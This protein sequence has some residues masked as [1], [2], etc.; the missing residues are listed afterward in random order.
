[1]AWIFLLQVALYLLFRSLGLLLGRYKGG[2]GVHFL[3]RTSMGF[4]ASRLAIRDLRESLITGTMPGQEDWQRLEIIPEPWGSLVRQNITELRESG[5]PVVPTLDR[6]DLLLS[7]LDRAEAHARSRTAQAWGQA[8]VCGSFVPVT[9]AAL[10]LLLPAVAELGL[11]WW[12]V[13]AVALLLSLASMVW[14]LQMGEKAKWAGLPPRCRPWWPAALCFGE[15]ILAALRSGL[16]VDIAWSR[17]IPQLGERAYPLVVSWGAVLWSQPPAEAAAAR[18]TAG[19]LQAWGGQLRLSIQ[20]SLM[21]GRPCTERIES[22]LDSLRQEWS[23][24]VEG[25]LAM[26]GNRTLKPLFLLVAPAMLCLLAAALLA[27][28]RDFV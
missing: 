3:R 10:H 15:R 14:M 22:A 7:E 4:T 20:R 17:A 12:C 27:S 16:P 5:L 1:M 24:R 11:A 2:F 8:W 26:L 21:E 28:I 13:A 9:A 19:M 25:E 23:A 6:I 18:G